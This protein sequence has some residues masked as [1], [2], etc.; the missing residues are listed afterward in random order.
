MWKSLVATSLAVGVV[1]AAAGCGSSSSSGSG[2]T[3]HSV[4]QTEQ[5]GAEGQKLNLSKLSPS[6]PDPSSPVTITYETWQ[7]FSKG[8]LP[9][10]AK[11]FHQIHPNISIKFQPVN[12]D[13]AETKL[14]TQIAGGNP[15]DVAYV[16]DG[17][18]GSF[19]PRGAI[20]NLEDYM[21]K[22]K[23]TPKGDYVP[24]FTKMVSYKNQMYGMPIDGESTALFYRTDEFK[25]AGITSPPKTWA[26]LLADAKKLT[27]PSKKQYGYALFATTGETSYYWY[28][29]LYQAGGRQTTPDDKTA[30]F[31]SPAGLKAGQFYVSL[32]NYSSPDLWGSDSWTARTTFAT[33]KTAMYMAGAWFAGEMEN[34]FKNQIKNNW[35]VAPLPTMTAGSPCATTIAGDAL[36]IPSAGHNHDA[37]WKWIEFLE[38]P[39][40]MALLN[41][42]TKSNPTTLLPPRTSL[43]NNPATF[44]T[45]PVLKPFAANMRCGI[46]DLSQNPN[47]GQ[48]DS[49]PLSDA[50]AHGIYGK[51]NIDTELKSAAQQANSLLQKPS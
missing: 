37:A 25:K 42:G 22:S 49:G 21:S 47:W 10:L 32:R 26:E 4:A 7:D 14:T 3:T 51:G 1:V 38:A 48:V 28:P 20:L 31:A 50:L 34:T 45:N 43:L 16:D 33:G 27:I 8:A 39:Q 11:E 35:A 40:N 2:G 30:A 13:S 15:P 18:V 19:A 12:A 23:A 46:T 6:I 29:F 9:A 24:A 44:K 17:T 5:Q 36:V 41:L